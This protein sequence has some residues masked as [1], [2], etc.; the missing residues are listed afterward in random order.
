MENVLSAKVTNGDSKLIAYNVK[1]YG[2]CKACTIHIV[3]CSKYRNYFHYFIFMESVQRYTNSTF[4]VLAYFSYKL[5]TGVRFR[6]K[7]NSEFTFS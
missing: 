6:Y 5:Y 4:N 1:V 3:V 2:A 7:N